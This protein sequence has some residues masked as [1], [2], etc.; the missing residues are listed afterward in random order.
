VRGAKLLED[1]FDDLSKGRVRYHKV[2]HGLALTEWLIENAPDELVE[3]AE[4]IQ[5]LLPEDEMP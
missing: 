2:Q 1:M 4:L 5:S 3:V